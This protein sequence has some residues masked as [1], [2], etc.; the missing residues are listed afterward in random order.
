MLPVQGRVKGK[1]SR[2]S[3]AGADCVFKTASVSSLQ[4]SSLPGPPPRQLHH[5]RLPNEPL[6]SVSAF[7]L[8]YSSRFPGCH[9]FC[10]P[11]SCLFVCLSAFPTSPLQDSLSFFDSPLSHSSSQPLARSLCCHWV[12]WGRWVRGMDCIRK[13]AED[14]PGVR[15]GQRPFLG[16]CFSWTCSFCPGFAW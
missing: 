15:P 8:F 4:G 11:V 1:R 6:K 13:A 12:I 14:E 7:L 3:S 16:F 10:L 2:R 9:S 5:H